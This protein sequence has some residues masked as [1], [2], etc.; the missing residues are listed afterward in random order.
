MILQVLRSCEIYNEKPPNRDSQK[1]KSQKISKNQNLPDTVSHSSQKPQEELPDATENQ[2][3][4]LQAS[5]A[6]FEAQPFPKNQTL[7]SPEIIPTTKE[8]PF[9]DAI[10]K[11]SQLELEIPLHFTNSIFRI[12]RQLL[13]DKDIQIQLPKNFFDPILLVEDHNDSQVEHCVIE[14]K[15]KGVFTILDRG[16]TQK[17]YFKDQFI[18]NEGIPITAGDIFILP[19]YIN[20]QMAS[21]TVEFQPIDN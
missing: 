4:K 19:V 21:L 8:N 16:N 13:D 20:N 17:T 11:I 18:K 3:K 9:Q 14:Q 15:E 6:G 2:I 1:K 12:G 10:L 5:L 7:E